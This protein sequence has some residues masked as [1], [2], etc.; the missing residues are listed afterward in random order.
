VGNLPNV[1]PA[2]WV[3]MERIFEMRPDISHM[4]I[5]SDEGGWHVY[6]DHPSGQHA[7]VD[8]NLAEMFRND[9]ALTEVE[10]WRHPKEQPRVATPADPF[11]GPEGG[12]SAAIRASYLAGEI[13]LD[14]F[15]KAIRQLHGAPKHQSLN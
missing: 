4:F 5:R 8:A 7:E 1:E 6:R 13:S 11:M 14:E 15:G 3:A 9:P 10:I 12:A 2:T